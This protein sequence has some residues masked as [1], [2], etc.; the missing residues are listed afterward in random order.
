MFVKLAKNP[1][2]TSM[3]KKAFIEGRRN[4]HY[5]RSKEHT[6]LGHNGAEYSLEE[7]SHFS[8][9]FLVTF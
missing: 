6:D 7:N 5:R 2:I 4:E 1:L 3:I 8:K 9:K